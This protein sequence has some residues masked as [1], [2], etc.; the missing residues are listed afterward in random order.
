MPPDATQETDDTPN[1]LH[2]D[3]PEAAQPTA[4]AAWRAAAKFF[5]SPVQHLMDDPTISEIMVNGP[6]DVYIERDGHLHRTAVRF[7]DE[8]A[9]LAAAR[10][11]A[12][13]VGRRIGQDTPILDGRLPDGERICVVLGPIASFGATINIRKFGKTPMTAE[14]L[15]QKGSITAEALSYLRA[16]VASHAN[17]IVSGGTGTGKTT[18]V[19]ILGGAFDDAERV[20][21]IEDTRELQINKPHVV[22]LEARPADRHGRG[23]VSIRDLFVASLRMRPDRIVVGEVRRGEALDMVQAMT[24]G[25]RGSISTLHA[26]SPF[27]ACQ[28]LETMALMAG[29]GLPLSA[30]RRQV[31]SAIDL[32]VQVGRFPGG[33]RRIT[34]ISR[35]GLENEGFITRDIFALARESLTLQRVPGGGDGA[36]EAAGT[37]GGPRP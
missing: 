10:H 5:L 32:V 28:R 12:Q 37:H 34:H 11:I 3:E 36:F 15:L 27:D 17:I 4:A 2:A 22:R 14:N 30:L 13:F 1:S 20:I 7:E 33:A 18:I 35:V 19:N 31:A 25:H 21:V 16:A 6:D 9:V 26:N 8:H 24:S 23:E 29:V